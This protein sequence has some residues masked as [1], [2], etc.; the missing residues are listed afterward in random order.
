M[1][2]RWWRKCKFRAARK[3]NE[4]TTCT[5]CVKMKLK[6]LRSYCHDK[7]YSSTTKN[8]Y[9][10]KLRLLIC[11]TQ[12]IDKVVILFPIA[13]WHTKEQ[14]NFGFYTFEAI[15]KYSGLICTLKHFS[16]RN[17]FS[18]LQFILSCWLRSLRT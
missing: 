12:Y 1:R 10:S 15:M 13:W 8:L 17:A 5:K 14:H 18:L 9:S 11:V 3:C 7:R 6:W 16:Y 4:N 2:K